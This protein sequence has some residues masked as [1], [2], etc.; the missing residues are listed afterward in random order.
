M[1]KAIFSG[2][3]CEPATNRSPSFSR[4]SSSVTTT[5]SPRAKAAI[6][7]SISVCVRSSMAPIL[8][9]RERPYEGLAYLAAMAEK[10][11]GDD[12]SDHRL[13]DRHRADTDAGVVAALGGD[14][15]LAAV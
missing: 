7:C 15:G 12:A 8:R 9:F 10:L 2:V 6:A 3:Q 5:I 1:M 13:A 4:S 11:V 14:F